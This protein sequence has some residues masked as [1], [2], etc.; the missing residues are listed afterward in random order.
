MDYPVLLGS[1]QDMSRGAGPSSGREAV[2]WD[3]QVV[4]ALRRRES[5]ST[6][7]QR[8]SKRSIDAFALPS[9]LVDVNSVANL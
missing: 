9:G 1:I 6:C 5:S 3:E 2:N 8:M 7:S 4:P